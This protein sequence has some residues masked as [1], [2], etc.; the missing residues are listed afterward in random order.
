MLA[1]RGVAGV[2]DFRADCFVGISK[3]IREKVGSPVIDLPPLVRN[4][5]DDLPIP[6]TYTNADGEYRMEGAPIGE[7][8]QGV[9]KLDWV[10]VSR[11]VETTAGEVELEDAV[12]SVGRTI[13]GIVIDME[14]D[15]L[16]GVEVMAGS[17]LSLFPW[18]PLRN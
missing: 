6:T 15:P 1:H 10:G 18:Q 13:H 17:E 9:D 12:L 14:G 2:Q 11:I 16:E 4:H 3:M 8:F 7:L 5:I